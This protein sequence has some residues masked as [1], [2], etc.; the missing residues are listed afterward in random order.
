MARSEGLYREG[1]ALAGMTLDG[2]ARP[3]QQAQ[4]AGCRLP[5]TAA[6]SPVTAVE[7]MRIAVS[8]PLYSSAHQSLYFSL[9]CC[10]SIGHGLLVQLQPVVTCL[11]V[12]R[13]TLCWC[14]VPAE[15]CATLQCSAVGACRTA[16]ALLG[17]RGQRTYLPVAWKLHAG[18][19]LTRPSPW[20]WGHARCS[21]AG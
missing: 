8:H 11:S 4:T 19:G 16:R 1:A 7:H 17:R 13:R 15:T 14:E 2:A 5:C 3:G 21:P 20:G 9:Y 12:S 18:W 6:A 10:P